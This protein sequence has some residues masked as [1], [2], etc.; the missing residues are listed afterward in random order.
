MN[1]FDVL[2]MI[3]LVAGAGGVAACGESDDG[4]GSTPTG[5]SP[6]NQERPP[7]DVAPG[8]NESEQEQREEGRE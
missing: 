1:G 4:A 5:E 2:I 6:L 8:P 7:Q 3:A